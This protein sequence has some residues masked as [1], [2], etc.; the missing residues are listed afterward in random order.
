MENENNVVQI[1]EDV[2]QEVC[3][4]LC[5]YAVTS[6]DNCE[7]DYIREKGYCPLDKLH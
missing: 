5:K 2:C 1:I 3:D 7:C 6:D 4:N